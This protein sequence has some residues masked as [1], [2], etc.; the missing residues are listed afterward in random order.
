MVNKLHRMIVFTVG[1][2][3]A[4]GRLVDGACHVTSTTAICWADFSYALAVHCEVGGRGRCR[5]CSLDRNLIPKT[6]NEDIVSVCRVLNASNR[7]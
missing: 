3:V 4:H 7:R 2:L 5:I 1:K 6:D